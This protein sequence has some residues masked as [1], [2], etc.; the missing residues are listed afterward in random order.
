MSDDEATDLLGYASTRYHRDG[1]AVTDY[2]VERDK[3]RKPSKYLRLKF[4]EGKV[5]SAEIFPGKT[6]SGIE[7]P[8]SGTDL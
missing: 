8:D 6:F 3:F 4:L 2:V 1:S 5:T 7:N